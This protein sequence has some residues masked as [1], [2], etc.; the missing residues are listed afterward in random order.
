I[1]PRNESVAFLATLTAR[2]S[3]VHSVAIHG[4]SV[5]VPSFSARARARNIALR[6]PPAHQSGSGFPAARQ[7]CATLELFVSAAAQTRRPISVKSGRRVN[8]FAV[9][10]A[11]A[12]S[13]SCTH[14]PVELFQTF[15][16]SSAALTPRYFFN[17][18]RPG[19]AVS[20]SKSLTL[21]VGHTEVFDGKA[22]SYSPDGTLRSRRAS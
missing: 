8:V 7:S 1:R 19:A 2:S 16:L 21:I 18:T 14:F 22:K 17:Q 11:I 15:S 6:Q 5:T 20:W 3:I 12:A 4:Q 9:P 10:M 13:Q